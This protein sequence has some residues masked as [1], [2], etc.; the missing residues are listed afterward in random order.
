MDDHLDHGDPDGVSQVAEHQ[1]AGDA[2]GD[3]GEAGVR[4]RQSLHGEPRSLS[5]IASLFNIDGNIRRATTTPLSL[6]VGLRY[7]SASANPA[8]QHVLRHTCT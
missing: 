6:V 7:R 4:E 1:C 5:L 8:S 2:G 3:G